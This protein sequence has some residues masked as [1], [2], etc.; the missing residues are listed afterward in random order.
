M[1]DVTVTHNPDESRYEGHVDGDLAGFADYELRDDLI[2]FPHTEVDAAFEGQGVASAIARY[3]L[4]DAR[5]TGERRV[6]PECPFFKG[7]VEK[8]PDYQSLVAKR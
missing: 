5:A 6:V 1:T 3:A 8:H 7:W 2:V 4:D